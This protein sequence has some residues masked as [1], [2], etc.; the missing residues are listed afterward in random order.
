MNQAFAVEWLQRIS[1]YWVRTTIKRESL[2]TQER[3]LDQM[4]FVLWSDEPK[5]ENVGS[6]CH[7]FMR[8]RKV[9]QMVPTCVVATVKL[10]AHGVG[11]LAGYTVGDFLKNSCT[12]KQHSAATCHPVWFALC[13][14]IIGCSTGQ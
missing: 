12:L 2:E 7:V 10:G 5:F 1:R 14:T 6:T 13:R 9:E 8:C 11:V 3:K 4:K